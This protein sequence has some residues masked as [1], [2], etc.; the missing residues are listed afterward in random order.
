M[1]CLPTPERDLVG[2]S[3][4]HVCENRVSGNKIKV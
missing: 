2:H 1:S 4:E 3:V